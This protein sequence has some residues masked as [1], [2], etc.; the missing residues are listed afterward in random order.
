MPPM[1]DRRALLAA[2]AALGL[3]EEP[4]DAALQSLPRRKLGRTGVEVPILGFG[5]A[6]TGIRRSQ[7]I[8]AALYH[9][10][11]DQGITYF[12]TAPTHTGYGRAQKQLGLVTKTRR[13]EM[14]L[15]TKCH[16]ADGEAALRMLE[17]N[18]KEL[19]T[20][21]ADLVHIHSLGD[22]D[23]ARVMGKNGVLQA[24]LRAKQKGLTRFVGISGHHRPASF[25]KIL[26]DHDIDVLMNAVNFVDRHTYGFEDRVW[27]AA[28]RKG[29]G[30]VAMKVYGGMIYD[31]PGMSNSKMPKEYLN[32]ALR[33]ALS[34][35]GASL[36]VLG[37]STREE[38][39]QNLKWAREFV[40]LSQDEQR[41][42]SAVGK[43]L[44]AGWGAHYGPVA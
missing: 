11:L 30:L 6:P 31:K 22:M 1:F 35:P 41:A 15:V 43:K 19:R 28:R 26:A 17:K 21:H 16:E 8:G 40:P 39:R 9:E 12:D 29:I 23:T 24:L 10:A 32:S 33:Y 13:K 14:F 2:G 20:D 38:L 5:T 27:S 37:M 36:A 25:L 44:A 3:S 18:L 42:L 34:L 7:E 4:S